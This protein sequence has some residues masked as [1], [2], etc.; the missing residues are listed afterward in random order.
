MQKQPQRRSTQ[1]PRSSP[2]GQRQPHSPQAPQKFELVDPRWIVTALAAAVGAAF[3][4]AYLTV[5]IVFYRTQWQLVLTPS[6]TVKS[7]PAALG[8]SFTEVHFGVD[9]S[10][11]PQ[12]Q[13]WW[14]PGDSASDPTV[15]MLHGGSGSMSD[16]LSDAR[17][18]R[19]SHLGVLLFDYRGFG[20]SGG[21][22]PT[23][24]LMQADAEAAYRYVT[25]LRGSPPG[26]TLLYGEGVGASLAVRLCVQ[27]PQVAALILQ[28]AQGDLE[29]RIR[30]EVRSRLIPVALLFNQDFALVAPLS[31]LT[32]PKLLISIGGSTAPVALQ[33]AADPKMLVELPAGDPAVLAESLR[34]FLLSYVPQAAGR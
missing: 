16:A 26:S 18:L 2:F 27:H 33:R 13:G 17:M 11:Q 8:M 30:A 7:T 29:P 15:L 23:E 6:R 1:A 22:H 24:P 20:S 28:S 34:R 19:D 25:E 9:A 14:I 12:L 32:T 10:G 31:S 3:M 5:C 4:L 21:Q